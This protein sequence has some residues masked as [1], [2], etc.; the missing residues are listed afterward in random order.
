MAAY[1]ILSEAVQGKL[2]EQ[3]ALLDNLL[4]KIQDLESE[5]QA[6]ID[7]IN[8][9]PPVEEL[10]LDDKDSVG[11]AREAYDNLTAEQ[12]ELITNYATLVAAE[13]K[14]ADLEAAAEARGFIEAHGDALEFTVDTVKIADEAAIKAAS[15]TFIVLSEAAQGKLTEQKALLDILLSKIGSLKS[16]VQAVIET[17][18]VLSPVEGLTLDDRD[19]VEAARE[20]YDNLTPEQ[21]ALVTNYEALKEAEEKIADLEAGAEAN[22]FK[23]AHASVL[24]LTVDT[25]KIADK[26]DVEAA[27]DAYEILSEAVQGKLAEEKSLLDN[28][29][30]KIESLESAVQAVIGTIDALLPVEDLTLDDS[31]AVEAAKKAYNNLTPEQGIVSNYATWRQPKQMRHGGHQKKQLW[32]IMPRRFGRRNFTN[33]R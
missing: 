27:L 15:S 24:A 32:T 26:E 2:A 29:L 7:A 11:A 12:K 9:L 17:I 31:N 18:D 22:S 16:A 19:A 4:S 3:K 21:Q 1:E 14:I 28:L 5:V 6:V 33:I 13:A 8:A 10:I 23:E 30:I 25:V 20:A